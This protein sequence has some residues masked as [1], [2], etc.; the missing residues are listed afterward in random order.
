[1][2][3]PLLCLLVTSLTTFA[4]LVTFIT[5]TIPERGHGLSPLEPCSHAHHLQ[6]H[7]PSTG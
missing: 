7:V 1:M 2:S 4:C 5:T 3:H 6:F